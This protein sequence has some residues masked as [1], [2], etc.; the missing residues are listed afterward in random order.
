MKGRFTAEKN[1]IAL[2]LRAGEELEPALDP[3]QR[4]GLAAVLSGIYIAV[5]AGEIAGGEDMKEDI[6]LSGFEGDGSGDMAHG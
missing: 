2:F 6:A 5:S 1:D 4:K 3:F